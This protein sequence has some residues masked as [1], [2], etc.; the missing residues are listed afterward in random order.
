[1]WLCNNLRSSLIRHYTRNMSSQFQT[2]NTTKA[3]S[4]IGPYSQAIIANGF[5][6]ASGQI[7]VVPETGNIISDDVKEQ[8]KQVIKNLTNVLE[9]ANSSLSQVVKTTVFI[10]DMNDFSSVNE[11]Y[12]ECFGS[13][14]PA[15]A[16]VEV[17]RLPKDVKVEIDAVALVNS[18]SSV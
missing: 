11:I 14:R 12:G 7:P 4:A 6:Y 18:V 16:C 9:A 1:M 13:S 3:P 5:V 2:V 8:T 15:R 17:S 10:K